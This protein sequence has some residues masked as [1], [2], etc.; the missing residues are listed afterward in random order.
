MMTS[1]STNGELRC[2]Y[3]TVL[4]DILIRA[5]NLRI[6]YPDQDICIHANDVAG[7]FR[8]LKMH[9]DCMP[10]FSCIVADFIFLQCGQAFGTDFAPGNWEVPRRIAEILATHLFD[11]KLLREKHRKYLDRLNWSKIL[12][13]KRARFSPA[14]ADSL[15]RGVTDAKGNVKRT[16]HKFF[17][18]DGIYLDVY[19]IVRLEQAIAASIE[20]IF[21]LLG[22]SDLD[23]RRDAVSWS[24]MEEMLIAPINIVLGLLINLRAMTIEAAPKL[25]AETKRDLKEF[26]N[27]RKVFRIN[28][29]ESLTGKLTNIA[30]TA[31]WLRH[32]LGQFYIFTARCLRVNKYRLCRTYPAFCHAIKLAKQKE[33]S[34]ISN[35]ERTFAQSQTAKQIHSAPF[36]HFISKEMREVIDIIQ[37]ALDSPHINTRAFIGHLIP[38]DPSGTAWSDSSLRAAGGYS[39]NMRFW[40]YIEWPEEVT[41]HT[42]IYIRDNQ[43]N[44][45][46]SINVLEYAGIIINYVASTH[47]FLLNPRE[48]DP[49]PITLLIADN[50]TAESWI[51]KAC[52]NSDIGRA[53]GRLQ[54]ALM[55]NN[56][57][58]IDCA[59]VC[60][61]ENKFA[62]GI[63]RITAESNADSYFSSLQQ[64]FPELAG[65]RRFHPSKELVSMVMDAICHKKFLDP[66]AASQRILSALGKITS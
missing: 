61:K 65:C 48:D 33:S 7:A 21:I 12:G 59:H 55:I 5:W 18:D 29:L 32:L 60:S 66:V 40:W 17:V 56:P 58:G 15:N 16:P 14:K 25:V 24:K 31:P 13:S 43:T 27:H 51:I 28:S 30:N 22:E 11:D 41:K 35:P 3:G 9:P 52:M 37:Q 39:I 36:Q 8:Q 10:A 19:D 49:H 53:L 26:G 47:Y 20:A 6:T 1:T 54:C 45:L 64:E 4:R 23:K 62:D 63:S 2:E 57:V 44:D 50:T 42:L 34:K 38:R 46:V